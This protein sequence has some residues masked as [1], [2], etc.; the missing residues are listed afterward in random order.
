MSFSGSRIQV[1]VKLP[2]QITGLLPAPKL[3]NVY[4][5]PSM[6]TYEADLGERCGHVHFRNLVEAPAY[7]GRSLI[8]PHQSGE[9]A[10]FPAP[11]LTKLYRKP[12]MST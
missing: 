11:K 1:C 4:T 8:R 9:T 7:L 3:T 12:S 10:P 5:H 6:S 2:W